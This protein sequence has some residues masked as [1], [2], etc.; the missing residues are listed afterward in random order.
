MLKKNTYYLKEQPMFTS[1]FVKDIIKD[2]KEK[3]ELFELNMNFKFVEGIKYKDRDISISG[4]GNTRFLSV[5]ILYVKGRDIQT[6]YF[7]KW[8]L[9]IAVKEWFTNANIDMVYPRRPL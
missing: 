5:I 7:D 1:Q 6:R 4:Y 9:E 2:I 3:P 8:K